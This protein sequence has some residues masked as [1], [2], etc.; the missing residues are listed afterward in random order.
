M[1]KVDLD[2]RWELTKQQDLAQL[3]ATMSAAVGSETL[4]VPTKLWTGEIVPCFPYLTT[5]AKLVYVYLLTSPHANMLGYYR[6]PRS[7]IEADL[8]LEAEEVY[9]ALEQLDEVGLVYSEEGTDYLW[10]RY[11][12]ATQYVA[13]AGLERDVRAEEAQR[14]FDA[15]PTG[16]VLDQVRTIYGDVLGIKRAS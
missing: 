8:Q 10:V 14:V 4:K 6:M 16:W 12:A 1:E 5:V 15:L 11:F 13:V 9:Q 3:L 2:S 7:Y